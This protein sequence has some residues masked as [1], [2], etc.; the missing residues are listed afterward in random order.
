MDSFAARLNA[1]EGNYFR[2]EESN[3]VKQHFEKLIGNGKLPESA[4][5]SLSGGI[6]HIGS[7]FTTDA[8]PLTVINSR[9]ASE[10]VFRYDGIPV[11]RSSATASWARQGTAKVSMGRSRWSSDGASIFSIADGKRLAQTPPKE[12]T[13]W[14]LNRARKIAKAAV[15][16]RVVQGLRLMPEYTPARAMLW[17]SILAVWGT[18]ILT[19]SVA[20]QLDIHDAS[21]ASDRLRDVVHPFVERSKQA[22][23]PVRNWLATQDGDSL[24]HSLLP[25]QHLARRMREQL[26]QR[27]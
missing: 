4:S 18:A 6:S 9:P 27:Q 7:E 21:D 16:E 10:V 13:N 8:V 26:G 11:P 19:A 25:I 3:A 23:Q 14:E 15:D 22:F 12:P 17:G 5:G 24:Q 2:A 1:A 20:R